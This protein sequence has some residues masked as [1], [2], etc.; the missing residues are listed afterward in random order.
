MCDYR[1]GLDWFIDH[2]YARFA[3]T[4]NYSATADLRT[5]QFTGAHSVVFLVCYW[6][7]LVMAPTMAVPLPLAQALSS[8]IPVQN[9]LA[10][11]QLQ[12]FGTDNTENTVLL[13][14]LAF[15]LR[16]LRNNGRSLQSHLL[17]TGLYATVCPW[18]ILSLHDLN[19]YTDFIK[20]RTEGFR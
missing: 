14:L 16:P 15:M 13:L 6:R 10:N 7:F 11:F 3:T 8:Q 20:F 12:N 18:M 1:W 19:L 17:A 2:L 5:L 4:S 9:S